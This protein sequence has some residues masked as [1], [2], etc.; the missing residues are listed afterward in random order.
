VIFRKG[1]ESEGLCI[2]LRGGVR[3]VLNSPDGP[4]QILKRFGPGRTFGDVSVF[5]NDRQPAEAVAIADSEITVIPRAELLD[6]LRS[7]PDA[8]I[9][10]IGLFAFRLR[11]Y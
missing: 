4:Q 5:D 6:L 1:D 11:A 9:E 3:T 7:N 8:A 2:V 10:V